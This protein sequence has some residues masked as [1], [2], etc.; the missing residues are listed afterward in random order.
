MRNKMWS[1]SSFGWGFK[2]GKINGNFVSDRCMWNG[3]IDEPSDL[4]D[5]MRNPVSVPLFPV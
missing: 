5:K 3:A 4:F 2:R 1:T